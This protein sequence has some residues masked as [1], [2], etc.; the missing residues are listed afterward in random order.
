MFC[1]S[2][3]PIIHMCVCAIVCVC[4]QVMYGILP[5]MVEASVANDPPVDTKGY[6]DQAVDFLQLVLYTFEDHRVSSPITAQFFGMIFCFI[7]GSL[8]NHMLSTDADV[9]VLTHTCGVRLKDSLDIL[10]RW[11]CGVEHS[12]ELLRCLAPLTSVV[13]LLCTPGKQLVEV[14][15]EL[16]KALLVVYGQ[17][18][19]VWRVSVRCEEE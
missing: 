1:V 8:L 2:T 18:Y 5:R 6:M 3:K 10:E 19:E 17:E 15:M 13:D 4:V 11:S 12:E 14:R 9:S 16:A 7:N